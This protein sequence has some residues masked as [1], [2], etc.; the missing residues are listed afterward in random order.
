MTSKRLF[1]LTFLIS[2]VNQTI[3][4]SNHYLRNCSPEYFAARE[5]TVQMFTKSS[6]QRW[7]IQ[8][9]QKDSLTNTHTYTFKTWSMSIIFCQNWLIQT[10]TWQK[11]TQKSLLIIMLYIHVYIV[12]ECVL[13]HFCWFSVLGTEPLV[14]KYGK[15]FHWALSP[16]LFTTLWDR[17]SLGPSLNSV[18][19]VIL[20]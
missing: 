16:A 13:L 18:S 15:Y 14:L 9:H 10:W 1:D 4:Y 17:V 20:S 19:Q 7:N 3:I 8:D 5:K 11:F 6:I 2:L 12:Y